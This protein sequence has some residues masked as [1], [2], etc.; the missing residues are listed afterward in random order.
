MGKRQP[1]APGPRN[2]RVRHHLCRARGGVPLG[3]AGRSRGARRL[4]GRDGE[5]H[6]GGAAIVHDGGGEEEVLRPRP[7]GAPGRA[8]GLGG[9]VGAAVPAK[10]TAT[11]VSRVCEITIIYFVAFYCLPFPFEKEQLSNRIQYVC[12]LKTKYEAQQ[13]TKKIG[14]LNQKLKILPNEDSTA[15]KK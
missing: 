2:L 11:D 12:L 9:E 15:F 4:P 7:R 1:P 14:W 3:G 6:A 13:P 10:L 8:Q 5:G